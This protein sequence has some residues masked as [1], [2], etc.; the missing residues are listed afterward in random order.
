[1]RQE[2]AGDVGRVDEEVAILDPDV[3]MR[4]ED[5]ELAREVLHRVLRADVPLERR[6]LLRDPVR[7][8]MRSGRGDRE[9]LEPRE[10]HDAAP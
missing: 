6:D 8:R 9:V 10:L 2:I 1:M 4:A 3:H 7:E 5:E